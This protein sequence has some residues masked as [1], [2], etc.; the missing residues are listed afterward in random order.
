MPQSQSF[1][2]ARIY[3]P[4]AVAWIASYPKVA[5]SVDTYL[6]SPLTVHYQLYS[7]LLLLGFGVYCYSYLTY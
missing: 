7:V 6:T 2:D 1:A 4:S 3:R 5:R